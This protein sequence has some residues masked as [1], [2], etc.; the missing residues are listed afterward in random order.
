M[1]LFLLHVR[2]DYLATKAFRLTIFFARHSVFYFLEQNTLPDGRPRIPTKI[3][4][5]FYPNIK[6]KKLTPFRPLFGCLVESVM[7]KF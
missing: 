6:R 4:P 5:F 1:R 7:D 3:G 2:T